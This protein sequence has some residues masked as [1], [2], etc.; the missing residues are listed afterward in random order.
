MA[1]AN[2]GVATL[3]H[4]AV[5]SN[6][7]SYGGGGLEEFDSGTLI[8]TDSTISGNSSPDGGGIES[9]GTVSLAGSIVS[10][11]SSTFGGGGIT[12]E[13]TGGSP[14]EIMGGMTI[15]ATTIS[16]NTSVEGGGGILAVGGP[17]TVTNSTISNNTALSG[18]GLDA[19]NKGTTVLTNTTFS[20]N[21]ATNSGGA[22][23]DQDGGPYANSIALAYVTIVSNTSG[24]VH[25]SADGISLL[26]TLIVGSTTGPNCAGPSIAD[27][28]YNLDSGTSCGLTKPTDLSNTNPLIGPLANNGGPTMTMAL[29]TG[30]PA[31]D[32][33]GTR[34]QG[35]P[36]TDQRGVTRP[37][38]LACDIGAF[39]AGH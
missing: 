18:G 11:N 5:L 23:Y 35:C 28:G 24:I 25:V 39:E 14:N 16:S 3:I 38:G 32:H 4:T 21:T 12:N 26:G 34:A 9:N 37:Q 7:A 19:A 31:I 1:T 17:L 30:S 6:T 8:V 27:L 22:I 2:G 33:G 20:G 10:N 13:I 36:A 15:T 29:L